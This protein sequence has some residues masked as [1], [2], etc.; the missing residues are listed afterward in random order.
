M[1]STDTNMYKYNCTQIVHTHAY[2][3]QTH[4]R[5]RGEG[6]GEKK[7]KEKEPTQAC[8]NYTDIQD[9][10]CAMLDD[11]VGFVYLTQP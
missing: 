9:S 8:L 2:H 6:L 1:T 3:T 11:F 7:R 10:N 4:T 5:G